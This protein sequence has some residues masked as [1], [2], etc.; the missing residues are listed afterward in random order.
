[1]K[2]ISSILLAG[3]W[4]VTLFGCA[5]NSS[6]PNGH[7]DSAET[8]NSTLS[9]QAASLTAN[10]DGL[11]P[12]HEPMGTGVGVMPGR[13]IWVYE[14]DCVD[15]ADGY[16]WEFDNFDYDV[17]L[18]MV[19]NGITAVGGAKT[20]AESWKALFRYHN[21]TRGK[22]NAEYV[23]GERI[24][25]K[26]NMNGAGWSGPNDETTANVFTNPVALRALLVSMV[27]DAGIPPECITVYDASRNI[28][29][30]MSE[31]CGQGTTAGVHFLGV[32]ECKQDR[33][34]AAKW[35]EDFPGETCFL[36]TCVTEAEYLINFA[37]LK[38]HS[39]NG[40]TLT[41][42]NHFGTIMNSNRDAAPVAAGIHRFVTADSM[43][44]YTVLIDLMGNYMLGEKTVLYLLDGIIVSPG[45]GSTTSVNSDNTRWQSAPF[46]GGYT[47]S[48]FFSQDPVA[49]DSVGADFLGNEPTLQKYNAVIHDNPNV[50]NYL[51]EAGGVANAPS[52]SVYYNGNGTILTNLGVH[53]HWNNCVD[54]QYSRNLGKDEG[55]ELIQ[56]G[57]GKE[58][59]AVENTARMI[60]DGQS[61]EITFM[62]N[63]TAQEIYEMLPLELT[64]TPYSNLEYSAALPDTP[65]Y[66][67][68]PVSTEAKQGTITYCKEYNSFVVVC[69]DHKDP[70]LEVPIADIAGS[71]SWMITAGDSISASISKD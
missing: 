57:A 70:F 32:Y 3:I 61:Y 17:I 5:G 8:V 10:Y 59:S 60:L 53:E 67:G 35:S 56:L 36:P 15:W 62:D 16:W 49:I 54:K 38:G 52:G 31:Y 40:I 43:N 37:D 34:Y 63:Q 14:P 19:R 33:D 58:E 26:A 2:R 64:L 66:E 69:Q 29:R 24:A 27:E 21:E 13:V 46:N 48:L 71:V 9:G 50:E 7:P 1:M 55:I 47:A 42:K 28:P 6:A 41:A 30:Y 65:V 18:S 22:E 20:P 4:A 23:S 12:Q 39:M 45:E 44:K 11:F 25:I 68:S 51:H